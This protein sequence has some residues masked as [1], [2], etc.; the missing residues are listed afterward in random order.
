M[1]KKKQKTVAISLL[2]EHPNNPNKHNNTQIEALAKSIECYGQYY[3]IIVD[4]DMNILCGHG[5][6]AA[7]E[8]LGRTEAEVCIMIGLS[9]KQ[10]LKLLVEDNKI[11]SLGFVEYEKVE[12]II[13]QI[14]EVDILGFPTDYV[15]AILGQMNTD[16]MGVDL[17]APVMSGDTNNPQPPQSA[18]TKDGGSAP[19][20]SGDTNN[21]QPPQSAIEQFEQGAQ[22][23]RVIRCP[24]C[25][26]DIAI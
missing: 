14:G 13:R 24:H 5:K 16:A 7:L 3:P 22:V 23:A 19:V 18:P 21:P 12:D 8:H 6:K 1:I 4:E 15:D 11:Q 25:G 9:E 2:K 20:M 17:S 26:K 10:K